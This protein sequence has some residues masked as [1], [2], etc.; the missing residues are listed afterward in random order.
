M[1]CEELE[2]MRTDSR[3]LRRQLRDKLE[4]SRTWAKAKSS[5]SPKTDYEPYLKHRLRSLALQIEDHL[6]RHACE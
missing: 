3:E 6:K 4:R 2:K 1:G 5:S